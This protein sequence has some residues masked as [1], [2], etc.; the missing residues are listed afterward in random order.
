MLY[1]CDNDV[2]S[3]GSDKN[4]IR[5]EI[6]NACQDW[7]YATSEQA[8]VRILERFLQ[9]TGLEEP[10]YNLSGTMLNAVIILMTNGESI[11]RYVSG[12]SAIGISA[13]EKNT[14][15]IDVLFEDSVIKSVLR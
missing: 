1:G 4:L 5:S 6:R 9:V 15:C 3:T 8:Q 13:G 14:I 2:E 7:S 10:N 11:N 12:R